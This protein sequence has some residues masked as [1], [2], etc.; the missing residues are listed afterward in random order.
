MELIA[1]LKCI[2]L[3]GV[4]LFLLGVTISWYSKIIILQW[5]KGKLMFDAFKKIQKTKEEEN[6]ERKS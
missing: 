6:G 1:I 4:C 2:L 5:F 3:G